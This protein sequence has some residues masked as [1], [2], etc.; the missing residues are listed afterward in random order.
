[1]VIVMVPVNAWRAK[2]FI[3]TCTSGDVALSDIEN[4]ILS[5]RRDK[6]ILIF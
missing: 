6:N 4:A 3:C 5:R 1:M 2:K